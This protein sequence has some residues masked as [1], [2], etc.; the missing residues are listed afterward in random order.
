MT[1][2]SAAAFVGFLQKRHPEI[3]VRVYAGTAGYIQGTG[4]T[5]ST[6]EVVR[7]GSSGRQHGKLQRLV[8][9]LILGHRMARDALRWADVILSLTDPPLLGMWIG[10]YRELR[11]RRTRWIEWTMDLFPEAF[12]A[13]RLISARS[14]FYRTIAALV[15]RFPADGY[16]CLGA[17]QAETVAR[18]RGTKG[19]MVILPSGI[20]AAEECTQAVNI[21]AWRRNEN[22]IVLA[23]AGNLGIPHLPELLTELV[24]AADPERFAFVFALRGEHAAAVHQ[25][26]AAQ[27][28]VTWTDHLEVAHA[29]VT[30]ACLRSEFTD[31]CVP[32][33]AVSSICLG[34]PML[35]C[36]DPASDTWAMFG[37][38]SWCM[39]V[40]PGG[41]F[42]QSL[43]QEVL[44]QIA[45]PAQRREKERRAREIAAALHELEA[46]AFCSLE[47]IIL[48]T[49]SLAT[50]EKHH[51][52]PQLVA[53]AAATGKPTNFA[54][55]PADDFARPVR[56]A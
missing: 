24:T 10:G 4:E 19:P 50:C 36:G 1:G 21:P 52:E 12:A 35:Y 18:T 44:S 9:S 42:A 34:R 8:Q 29:D 7:L 54:A 55:C 41:N 31:I 43:L 46:S 49:G 26:L 27:T 28:H 48:Q 15:R 23:Y 16:V 17:A 33:K 51:S 5:D 14:P 13:A 45:D 22:R 56:F 20:V 47:Q 39:P 2:R 6:V 3:E 32:S 53:G 37:S 40:P 38:A 30:I 25:R 11:R